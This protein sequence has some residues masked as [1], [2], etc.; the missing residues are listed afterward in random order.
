[1]YRIL[2]CSKDTYITNKIINNKFRATDANVG[3]AGTLDL[4]KLY[5]ESISGSDSAPTELTRLMVKFDLSSLTKGM[6]EDID[7]NSSTFK[8]YLKMHDVY[9]GQTTPS[10]FKLIAFPLAK[11]FDEGIGRNIITFSDIDSSNW[12]TASISN[13]TTTVW[14]TQG[15]RSSG[16]LGAGG[17]DVIVSGSL[18]G[19]DGTQTVSLSPEQKFTLGTED[20]EIDVLVFWSEFFL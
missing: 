13:G 15:A 19:P 16:S 3:Q 20:F 1:M 12:V 2:S 8:C 11:S 9:G 18:Q 4:F 14:G 5:D 17:I 7:I 10:N 6:K